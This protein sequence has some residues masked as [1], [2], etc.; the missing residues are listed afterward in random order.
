MNRFRFPTTDSRQPIPDNRFPTTD[1]DN[2]F[3][4]SN[5]DLSR[6]LLLL[7]AATLYLALSGFECASSEVTTARV[8]LKSKDYKR[9]EEA[10][11]KEVAALRGNVEAWLLLGDIYNDQSRW[12]EMDEAYAKAE[13]APNASISNSQRQDIAA[14][15]QL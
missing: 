10:L 13:A 4:I 7:C 8:A 6:S 5:M 1:S 15:Q 3:P 14:S 2:R 11:K 9:A 12:V